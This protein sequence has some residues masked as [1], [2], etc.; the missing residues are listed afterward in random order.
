[1][2]S[3][4]A[5]GTCCG[6]GSRSRTVA[7]SLAAWLR[8]TATAAPA[9]CAAAFPRAPAVSCTK[10]PSRSRKGVGATS[11]RGGPD[12][13][14]L[15]RAGGDGGECEPVRPAAGRL[16]V[17]VPVQQPGGRGGRRNAGG[18]VRRGWNERR[19]CRRLGQQAAQQR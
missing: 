12:E 17:L 6:S 16:L 7:R 3:P 5:S 2:T 10:P 19:G 13:R 18:R 8:S 15:G 14:L 9:P 4:T 11:A 1:M